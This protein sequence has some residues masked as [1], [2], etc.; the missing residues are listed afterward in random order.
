MNKLLYI[1]L[2]SAIPFIFSCKKD[3][4]LKKESSVH[5]SSQNITSWEGKYSILIED[6][7]LSD[8][9]VSGRM[10]KFTIS[11]KTVTLET[12]SYQE[13][14]FCDGSYLWEVKGDNTLNLFY[15]G[16]SENCKSSE[17]NFIIKKE[18]NKFL[19]SSPDFGSKYKGKWLNINKL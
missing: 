8:E 2:I 12:E 1:F 17:P 14:I 4:A 15:N 3:V 13:P 18:K 11:K 16:S 9:S 10:W 19:I 7:A 6:E 5:F